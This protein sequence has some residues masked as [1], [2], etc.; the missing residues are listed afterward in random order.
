MKKIDFLNY[1]SHLI[2]TKDISYYDEIEQF[3]YFYHDNFIFKLTSTPSSSS[4]IIQEEKLNKKYTENISLT[5]DE[6]VILL[7]KIIPL[8]PTNH[9]Y[10]NHKIESLGIDIFNGYIELLHEF[11]KNYNPIEDINKYSN[12]NSLANYVVKFPLDNIVHIC[13]IGRVSNYNSKKEHLLTSVIKIPFFFLENNTP[14]SSSIPYEIIIPSWKIKEYPIL[15]NFVETK[16][17]GNDFSFLFENIVKNLPHGKEFFKEILE[18]SM[19]V[20]N[21]KSKNNKI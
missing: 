21:K 7:E 15:D 1:I 18:Y 4:L 20:L 3:F 9:D 8:I 13:R 6:T 16:L 2:D 19:P 12:S 11:L 5:Y 14:N 10:S 17:F